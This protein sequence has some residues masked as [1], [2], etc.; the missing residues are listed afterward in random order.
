MYRNILTDETNGINAWY[1][2][3]VV[4]D[5]ATTQVLFTGVA[6]GSLTTN[7]SQPY[8]DIGLD[9]INVY[10]SSCDDVKTDTCSGE[11]VV[12]HNLLEMIFKA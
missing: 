4:I 8:G 12:G 5:G 11:T 2:A 3:Y 7:F 9:D 1:Q 10:D 6:G